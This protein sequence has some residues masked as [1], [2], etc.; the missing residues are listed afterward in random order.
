MYTEHN[1]Y[2]VEVNLVISIRVMWSEHEKEE[3]EK[4]ARIIERALATAGYRV[5]KKRY[6]NR[7]N[8]G[9][10]IYLSVGL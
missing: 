9:E 10:R 8:S 3:A 5:R 6:P 4:L 7:R 1:L 2:T